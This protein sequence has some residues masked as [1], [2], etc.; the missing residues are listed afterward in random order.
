[1]RTIN[2]LI[3][4][5]LFSAAA[6]AQL[7]AINDPNLPAAVGGVPWTGYVTVKLNN[8]QAAQPLLYGSTPL[9]GFQQTVCI[10]ITRQDCTSTVPAGTLVISLYANTTVLPVGTSYNA[11]FTASRGGSLGN[12]TWIVHVGDTS[13]AQ[14]RSNTTPTPTST[15]QETQLRLTPGSIP[16]GAA[17]GLGAEL[18]PT[19]NGFALQ[20]VGGYPAWA[21]PAA[22]ATCLLSSSSYADPTWLTSLAGS[23]ISG[24][25][26][27]ATLSA[28]AT[29]LATPRLINTV[30]FDGTANITVTA[31]ALTLTGTALN[32]TVVTSSLTAIGTIATGTWQATA[33]TDTYI[34]SAATWNAKQAGD[35]TLTALAAYNTNG[36]LVQTAADTFV[37]RTLTGTSARVTIT[38]GDGV[39]GN[40]T[41]DISSSYVG[42]ATITTLGTI[43][44]GVW[45]GTALVNAKTT[46]TDL[47]TASAIVARDA[48]GNFTAGT[49]TASLTGN[50]ATAS[51]LA[52]TVPNT[53]LWIGQGTGAPGSSPNLTYDSATNT[54]SLLASSGFA[55][56][57][58]TGSGSAAAYMSING[59]SSASEVRQN[60]YLPVATSGSRRWRFGVASSGI[61]TLQQLNDAGGAVQ[62]A[63]LGL[64]L[65]GNAMFMNTPVD[66]G[67]NRLQV[68]GSIVATGPTE[69]DL[70]LADASA[71]S[72]F[73]N[74]NLQSDN[75][76][77]S[78]RLLTDNFSAVTLTAAAIFGTGN[79]VVASSPTDLGYGLHAGKAGTNGN[80]LCMD[81]VTTTGS[82]K[83]LF[84]AGQG[85]SGN[86]IE[87]RGYNAT[88]GSGTL[89]ASVGA[90]GQIYSAVG[91]ESAA[92]AYFR[93]TGRAQIFSP[94][95]SQI[96]LYN[97][98]GSAFSLLQFGGTTSGFPAWKRSAAIFQAR[99]AD[100]SAYTDVQM[101]AV[102]V[103]KAAPS[104]SSD[105]C[106]A[107]QM[108]AGDMGGTKYVFYCVSSGTIVRAPFASF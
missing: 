107:S 7:Q 50:A 1:M 90:T 43:T 53:R 9:M 95:D 42:Q 6:H 19:T 67:V 13:L 100:D 71:T 103:S 104:A 22:C 28:A 89:L 46:A 87:V 49:I 65:T 17:N 21:A 97:A 63:G 78:F 35:A 44:T 52:A 58:V 73:R 70:T 16:Y 99:L 2:R 25:V 102:I 36:L 3:L 38:N 39:S 93:W 98:G 66:D 45:S 14:I 92:G 61:F 47:N 40:P 108:W 105:A 8:P 24:P 62:R 81:P 76:K 37:G 82:S 74:W 55:S 106:T 68:E 72:G 26:P 15:F 30:A 51:A 32:P 56:M 31:A 60:F 94:A 59:G 48:S 29:A 84:V 11:T 10:G 69:G 27:S 80:F 85:Q 64:G 18:A 101:N 5:L 91:V 83:C 86:I 96:T 79:F 41:V 33:I 75:S 12:E 88:P 4:A 23:K 54:L 57:E 34:S 20:L 77:L